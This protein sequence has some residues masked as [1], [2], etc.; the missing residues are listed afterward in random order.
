MA[1]NVKPKMN[2]AAVALGHWLGRIERDSNA[3]CGNGSAE[4]KC[5]PIFGEYSFARFRQKF[6]NSR[7]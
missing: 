7:D 3:E 4:F 6:S 2:A 1:T 5:S